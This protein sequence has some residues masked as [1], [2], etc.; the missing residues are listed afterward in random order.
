MKKVMPFV[1]ALAVL[2]VPIGVF[3]Q[4]GQI[5]VG[6]V[7]TTETVGTVSEVSPD[8]IV[9]RSETSTTPMEYRYTESTTYVDDTG[10]AVSIETVKS[11]LPVTVY[12]TLEGDRMVADKVVVQKTT[13]TTTETPAIEERIE[14]TT[15]T[16]E[17]K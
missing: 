7:T 16:I 4:Q 6:T 8:T 2:V 14:T 3:A 12:Y 10:A 15:R 11:G 5:T 1:F 9:I 13:T 17:T